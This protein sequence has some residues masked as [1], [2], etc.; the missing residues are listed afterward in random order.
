[1]QVIGVQRTIVEWVRLVPNLDQSTLA[2]LE[3]WYPEL[4]AGGLLVL[5]DT[6]EFAESAEAAESAE[7]S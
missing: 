2:E 6:S 4:A 5:H 1:M 7:Q 3:S